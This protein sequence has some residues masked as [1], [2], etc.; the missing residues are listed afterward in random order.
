[1]KRSFIFIICVLFNA[2][3]FAQSATLLQTFNNVANTLKEYGIE[4]QSTKIGL[5][6]TKSIGLA[7]QH[8][9]IIFYIH[10]YIGL[11]NCEKV[12]TTPLNTTRFELV[13]TSYYGD[14]LRISNDNNII[15]EDK[16]EKKKDILNYYNFYASQNVIH[17]I[18][19]ELVSLQQQIEAEG[20]N[21]NIGIKTNSKSKTTKKKKVGRYSNSSKSKKQEGR[22]IGRYV[23]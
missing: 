17:K 2:L 7:I 19:N 8:G 22:K 6:K 11:S 18:Y 16:Y 1:M 23:Q 13:Y 10:D 3:S 14:I 20:F 12:L 4:S 5:Y 15:C 9:N 21:G